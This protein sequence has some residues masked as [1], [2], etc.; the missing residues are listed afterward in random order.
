M[1]NF[2]EIFIKINFKNKKMQKFYN[3]NIVLIY[4]LFN[5]YE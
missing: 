5:S 4:T 3:H 2:N 1:Q